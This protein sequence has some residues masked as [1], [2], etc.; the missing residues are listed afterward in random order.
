MIESITLPLKIQRDLMLLKLRRSAAKLPDHY[1]TRQLYEEQ[2]RKSIEVKKRAPPFAIARRLMDKLRVDE[3]QLQEMTRDQLHMAFQKI[4]RQEWRASGQSKLL[5]ALT[6]DEMDQKQAK[7]TL[8]QYLLSDDKFCIRIR[9]RLRFDRSNIRSTLHRQKNDEEEFPPDDLCECCSY[10][11]SETV[12]HLLL[13]CAAYKAERDSMIAEAKRSRLGIKRKLLLRWMLGGLSRMPRKQR[14][15]AL[16]LSEEYL[17]AISL[18]RS[19]ILSEL[20]PAADSR[21]REIAL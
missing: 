1:S 17:K 10:N 9:A 4:H 8:P 12:S 20:Y 18:T 2:A 19:I 3:D 14:T 15:R 5:R 21:A 6:D 7:P 11:V 13:S 16:E